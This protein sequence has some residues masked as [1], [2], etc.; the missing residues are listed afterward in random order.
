MSTKKKKRPSV[1]A[2]RIAK[3][4]EE[5]RRE[6]EVEHGPVERERFEEVMRRLITAPPTKAKRG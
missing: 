1:H 2:G 3:Y 5:E 4:T 6:K